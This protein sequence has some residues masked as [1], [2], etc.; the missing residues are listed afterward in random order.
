M[1][2]VN[3]VFRVDSSSKIGSGHIIRCLTLARA[4]RDI[5][6]I[7]SFVCRALEGNLNHL[8]VSEGFSLNELP[9]SVAGTKTTYEKEPYHSYWREVDWE[10]D[11]TE[12]LSIL[13]VIKPQWLIVD[14][15][16]LW[17]DWQMAVAVRRGII[18]FNHSS[19]YASSISSSIMFN[20]S[21]RISSVSAPFSVSLTMSHL[22]FILTISS[23]P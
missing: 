7:C 6:A 13:S 20:N 22:T 12:T 3:Y 9:Q 16:G 14:H 23:A 17:H 8:V 2:T 19:M 10:I 15:Y 21:N 4:L 18:K 1:E 5:G 11:A